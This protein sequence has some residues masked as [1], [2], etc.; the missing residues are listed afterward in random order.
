MCEGT[1]K[2]AKR[3]VLSR[4]PGLQNLRSIKAFRSED[5]IRSS[6]NIAGLQD[7]TENQHFV[8]TPAGALQGSLANGNQRSCASLGWSREDMLGK[9]GQTVGQS[10]K[11]DAHID[12]SFDD[13]RDFAALYPLL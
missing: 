9:D 5:S 3:R 1:R 2:P 10:V 11:T 6:R 12:G 4:S 8:Y 7:D 13:L